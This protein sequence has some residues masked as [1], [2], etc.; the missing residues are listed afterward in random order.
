MARQL[1]VD[2][3]KTIL[4]NMYHRDNMTLKEIAN[5]LNMSYKHIRSLL[6]HYDISRRIPKARNQFGEKNPNWKSGK[7]GR[8][9]TKRGYVYIRCPS[10]PRASRNHNY[11]P[12][13]VLIM[14]RYLQRYLTENELVHHINGIR[15]DNRIENLQVMPRLGTNSHAAYHNQHKEPMRNPKIRN[16]KPFI[17][18]QGYRLVWAPDHPNVLITGYIHEHR[19][20]MSEHLDRPLRSKEIVHHINGNPSDNRLENLELTT[21]SSLQKKLHHLSPKI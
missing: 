6:I 5:K 18:S 21:Q 9:I 2:V 7:D 12:E 16:P 4:E 15:T 13:Q 20:V 10:H 1:V 8:R 11:V 14:E 19:L 3:E 17:D